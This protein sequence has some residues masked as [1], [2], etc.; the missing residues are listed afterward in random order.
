ME[1]SSELDI[2]QNISKC[3]EILFWNVSELG[4]DTKQGIFCCEWG[5]SE[6]IILKD[7]RKK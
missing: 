3:T 7:R 2:P 1:V 6:K 5:E 4:N